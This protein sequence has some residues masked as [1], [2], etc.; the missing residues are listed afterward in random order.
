MGAGRVGPGGVV[1]PARARASTAG[2]PWRGV[3]ARGGA[4]GRLS[5]ARSG[6]KKRE[7]KE[8][9]KGKG[10]KKMEKE[11]RKEEKEG[12]RRKRKREGAGFAAPTVAGRARAPVARDARDEGQ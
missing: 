6:R 1:R 8:E 10:E 4:E 7:G 9:E 11:K 3:D 5:R 12:E 2:Q